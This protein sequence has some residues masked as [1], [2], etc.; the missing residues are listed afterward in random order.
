[1]I[2]DGLALELVYR[3]LIALGIVLAGLMLYRLINTATLG[4][5]PLAGA[6]AGKGPSGGAGVALLQP[7]PPAPRARPSSARRSSAC[8]SAS[9][10]GWKWSR[11]MPP[12]Q[13]EIASQW[14]VLSV[15]T[16]FVIDAQGNPRYVN[17]GVAPLDK[18]AAPVLPRSFSC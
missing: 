8:R 9:A 5:R 2:S 17:H 14:G 6:W 15:P 7:R 13:P 18:A 1:M 4:A 12:A 16:T 10:S 3:L 11:S